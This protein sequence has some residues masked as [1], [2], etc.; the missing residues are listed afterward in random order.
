MIP[1]RNDCGSEGTG[2]GVG[3][4]MA[5]MIDTLFD[6]IDGVSI[7]LS[8]L[9]P[10]EI[11]NACASSVSQQYRDLIGRYPAE[12]IVL[13]DWHSALTMADIL[14]GTHPRDQGYKKIAAIMWDAVRRLERV[15]QPPLDNG[16]NDD[17]GGDGGDAKCEKVA[18]NAS[19]PVQTQRG[20][21]DDDGNYVH[22]SAAMGNRSSID[23]WDLDLD[24]VPKHVMFA[25]I[26]KGDP[27]A[28]RAAALDD[29]IRVRK[30][31]EKEWEWHFYMNE[32][33]GIWGLR[34]EDDFRGTPFSP[35]QDCNP[36]NA[37]KIT[38]TI[39]SSETKE[40]SH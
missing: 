6:S 14:E 29:Q 28:P 21:G 37:G 25:N 22:N 35:G 23:H 16:A 20:S 24:N 5:S 3:A 9:A 30:M 2:E 17:S 40:P 13:A 7:V 36:D 26:V 10:K 31:G 15:I 19:G 33:N 1:S 12:R 34:P 8:T 11:N 38:S 27:N 4:K 32:G 18:G 39:T